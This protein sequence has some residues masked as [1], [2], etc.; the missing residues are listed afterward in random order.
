M[1]KPISAR[2]NTFCWIALG[3]PFYMFGQAVN[4]IIR[5]DGSPGFAMFATVVGAVANIILGS[6]LYFPMRMA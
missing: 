5:S 2:E 4:P 3:V 6:D 1:R